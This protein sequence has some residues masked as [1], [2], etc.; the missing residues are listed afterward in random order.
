MTQ[1]APLV[2]WK[3]FPE[4]ASL[5]WNRHTS[6]LSELK[7]LQLYESNWAFIDKKKMTSHEK[8]FVRHLAKTFASHLHV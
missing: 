6:M 5:C 3:D 2:Y 1:D 7:A 8:N 4:L